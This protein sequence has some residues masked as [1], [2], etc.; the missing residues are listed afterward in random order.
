MKLAYVVPIHKGGSRGLPA[1][2][3]PVSLTS[4]IMK[5]LERLV[6]ET[7][8]NHLEVNAMLNLD[9]HGFRHKRSCLSQLLEHH[10]RVLKYL[11]DGSNVDCIYLDFAKA[12]DKVDIGIL[13]HKIK[14]MGFSGSLGIFLHN[15]LSNREQSILANGVKSRCSKVK[16]GVPQGTVL[17]PILF[18][19]MI[20][21]INQNVDSHISL[22]CDDTRVTKQVKTEDNVEDLQAEL[23]KLYDWQEE[24]NMLFNGSKFEMLRYGKDEN[25]RKNTMYFTPDMEDVI[26]ERDSLRDLGV[27]M[28]RSASFKDHVHLVTKKVNKKKWLDTKNI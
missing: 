22:F 24:N 2:F 8:V 26:E 18:L 7:L 17:G 25:L 6:R 27:I 19:I 1:N 4:H 13:S 21:D 23:E 11:E 15:F 3:R 10:D 5:T 12:F 9:Q 20:N 16:S 14:K 28:N